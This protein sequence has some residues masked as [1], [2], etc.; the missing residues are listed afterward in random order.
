VKSG[1]LYGGKNCLQIDLD[2][3]SIGAGRRLEI[4]GKIIQPLT[5]MVRL[6]AA[7]ET[8]DAK[9]GQSAGVARGNPRS[10]Q[11]PGSG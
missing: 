4:R 8:M 11:K 7:P 1:L 9:H 10:G 6:M 3:Q 5:A 2:P